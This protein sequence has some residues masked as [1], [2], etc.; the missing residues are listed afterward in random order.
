[1]NIL[2]VCTSNSDRSPALEKHFSEKY[3]EHKYRSVGINRYHCERKG[4]KLLHPED[5][6]WAN[7]II[8]AEQIHL[9]KAT[10]LFRPDTAFFVLELG[11]YEKGKMAGYVQKAEE[12][13]LAQEPFCKIFNS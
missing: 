1:M 8:F 10:P 3:T 13:L 5:M 2:F 11:H 7:L 4:T 6:N 9:K 12:K